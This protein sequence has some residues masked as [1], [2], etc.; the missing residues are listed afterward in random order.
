MRTPT[1]ITDAVLEDLDEEGKDRRFVTALAR[2]LDVLRC[3]QPGEVSLN[4]QEIAR[5][6][7]LP[8]PTIS[9]LTYTLTRLGYLDYSERYG[10]YQL[11]N[12]VLSLGYAMLSSLDIRERAR[13]LMQDLADH[14]DA[15]ISLGGR[16]RL[17]MVYLEVCRGPGA[18]TLRI[19]VG[20]R[21]PI[22][23]SSMGRA[24]L[25]ALP[26]EERDYLLHHLRKHET[27]KDFERLKAGVMRSIDEIAERGFCIS[28]GEWRPDV[29]AVGVPVTTLD[30]N[31]YAVNCGGPAFKV[32][33]EDL[34]N[35]FGPRLVALA[36]RLSGPGRY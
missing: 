36:R 27:R 30:R 11:G 6:T 25:A 26:E 20:A 32:S 31:V 12:G 24:L 17:S 8:K 7:G 10:A 18:V 29:N 9:R 33:R 14:A 22:A 16:D 3:F 23:S 4:N 19:D 21:I 28:I 34:E 5:R 13:P 35:D 1:K 15:T 2:G